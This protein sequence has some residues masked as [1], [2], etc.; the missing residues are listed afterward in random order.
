MDA[1][2]SRQRQHKKWSEKWIK[3][4]IIISFFFVGR[5][6]WSNEISHFNIKSSGVPEPR[7]IVP[8]FFAY[9]VEPLVPNYFLTKIRDNLGNM[10]AWRALGPSSHAHCCSPPGGIVILSSNF[11]PPSAFLLIDCIQSPGKHNNK[12]STHANKSNEKRTQR[13]VHPSCTQ[14][15]HGCQCKGKWFEE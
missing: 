14:H 9:I 8:F 5:S 15:T 12:Q 1:H 10:S 7:C 4:E 13:L 11:I 6:F 2:S 3:I